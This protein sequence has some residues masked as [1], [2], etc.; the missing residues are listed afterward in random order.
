MK[1]LEIKNYD[2]LISSFNGLDVTLLGVGVDGHIAF[3]EPGS[4]IDSLTR[5]VTLDIQ[6]RK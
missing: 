5:L 2:D 4:E 3:N 6:T 1:E